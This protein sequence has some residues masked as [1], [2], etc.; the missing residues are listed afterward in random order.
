MILA[1]VK[2]FKLVEIRGHLETLKEWLQSSYTGEEIEGRSR[3]LL[4]AGL[5][6]HIPEPQRL[7]TCSSYDRLTVRGHG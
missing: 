7:V 3:L 1:E 2:A 4:K 5:T 6:E